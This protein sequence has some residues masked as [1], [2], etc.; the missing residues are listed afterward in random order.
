MRSLVVTLSLLLV[1]G[2]ACPK[3]DPAVDVRAPSTVTSAPVDTGAPGAPTPDDAPTFAPTSTGARALVLYTASVEGYVTP[4]GCTSEPLGGVA[5]LA[6]TFEEARAAYGERV[7]F[8]DGGDLLFERASDT[9]PADRCQAEARHALLV[10]TYARMGLVGTVLGAKDDVRGPA[11]RDRLLAARAIP[12]LDAAGP[13]RA[14]VEGAVHQS[15]RLVTRGGVSLGFSGFTWSLADDVDEPTR[16]AAIEVER[17]ALAREAT[18]LMK[19]GALAV[20]V[21][22]QAPR[23][24]TERVVRDLADVDVVIQGRAPG[25]TPVAPV[26]AGERGPVVVASGMQAQHLGVL[27]FSLDGR[28][29]GVALAL[30]DRAGEAERRKKLLDVRIAKY[31][32]SL[33]GAEAGARRAFVEEKLARAKEERGRVL[34]DA[35]KAPAPEGPHVRARAIALTR[36]RSEEKTAQAAL[37]A[38]EESIP[39]L[40]ATC[41]QDV[42]C[43]EPAKGAAVYVGVEACFMCHKDAVKFWRAQRVTQPGTDKQGNPVTRTLG[44]SKAWQTLVDDKKERDRECVGCHSV[45]FNVPGGYCRTADVDFRTDVQCESC[46]GPGSLHVENGDPAR[47][48]SAGI[49]ESTCRA[50]HHVPHIPTTESFVFDD[51][52][53]HVLGPGHGQ[54]RY[55]A[56]MKARAAAPR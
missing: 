50:C 42:T 52:L 28:A 3:K 36:R 11:W 23:T 19:E 43:E 6:G 25:E 29:P 12:T 18:R 31:E 8:V 16:A 5:R 54:Q 22:A 30:D 39:T 20:V 10:D 56:L 34:T 35:A 46:H 4:C 51:K 32:Q 53:T 26:R 2:A 9:L 33:V 44:H 41:E 24:I 45:G 1:T 7:F 38:Y 21:V 37:Q 48:V 55:D 15:G 17:A 13:S 14:L 49:T 40:T 47:I 27:E